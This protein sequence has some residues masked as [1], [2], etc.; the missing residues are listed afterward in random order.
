MLHYAIALRDASVHSWTSACLCSPHNNK[1][2]GTICRDVRR[3]AHLL[4]DCKGSLWHVLPSDEVLRNNSGRR[5]G[6]GA[7]PTSQL[8]CLSSIS[9]KAFCG[10]PRSTQKTQPG[11]ESPQR[12]VG[13]SPGKQHL[14]HTLAKEL[15]QSDEHDKAIYAAPRQTSTSVLVPLQPRLCVCLLSSQTNLLSHA[16]S[17]AFRRRTHYP[18]LRRSFC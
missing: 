8:G 12:P 10:S 17:D 9:L 11:Q 15:D 3:P 5:L 14:K 1:S 13:S 7:P 2:I 16:T 18:P 4:A 6:N